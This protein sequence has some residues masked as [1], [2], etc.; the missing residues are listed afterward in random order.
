[1]TTI[2]PNETRNGFSLSTEGENIERHVW[3]LTN[4]WNEKDFNT[5]ADW[6]TVIVMIIRSKQYVERMKLSSL[7]VTKLVSIS[8]SQ[9]IFS[10][11]FLWKLYQSLM[12][13]LTL[14]LCWKIEKLL[15]LSL[16]GL[17]NQWSLKKVFLILKVFSI[18]CQ[19][20]PFELEIVPSLG[21]G[22]KEY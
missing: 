5:K 3:F 1:M 12:L 9:V 16:F 21:L 11:D 22:F 14:W 2:Q 6:V 19:F 17:K 4:V 10:L 18:I 8:H 13:S 15:I 7:S 20:H